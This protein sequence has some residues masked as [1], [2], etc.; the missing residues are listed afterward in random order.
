M[1]TADHGNAEQMVDP[2]TGGPYTA[3]TL[4]SVPF[5]VVADALRGKSLRSGGALKD[6][7]PTIMT[8]MGLPIPTEMEGKSLLDQAPSG[9]SS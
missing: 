1:I 4:N 9:A 5:I 6:I 3:H 2:E 8:L 7:A